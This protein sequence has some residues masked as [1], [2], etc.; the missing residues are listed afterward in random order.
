MVN[1]LYNP[2]FFSIQISIN[3][4]L[5][6][7]DKWMEFFPVLNCPQVHNAK[8]VVSHDNQSYLIP[9]LAKTNEFG[10]LHVRRFHQVFLKKRAVD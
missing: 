2:I 9:I 4:F 5:N 7:K 1:L 10:F 6:T 8:T 3:R